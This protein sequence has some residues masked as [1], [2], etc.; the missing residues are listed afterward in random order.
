ME[1]KSYSQHTWEPPSQA[2]ISEWRPIVTLGA[3]RML[4][5]YGRLTV[6]A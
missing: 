2:A 4:T 3:L 1:P 5:S 6:G